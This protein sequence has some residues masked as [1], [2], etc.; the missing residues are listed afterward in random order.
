MYGKSDKLQQFLN[1]LKVTPYDLKQPVTVLFNIETVNLNQLNTVGKKDTDDFKEVTLTTN[2][3]S[4]DF[5]NKNFT[6]QGSSTNRECYYTNTCQSTL[7]SISQVPS[8]IN[9]EKMGYQF[10]PSDG[11]IE[12]KIPLKV[13]DVN[14]NR[15]NYNETSIVSE[16]F[17]D[18][19]G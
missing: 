3:T 5:T 13:M 11:I 14:G 17:Y 10:Y 2:G 4:Y 16:S 19:N 7:V 9:A 6:I 12:V 1:N 8:N 18:Y 15:V